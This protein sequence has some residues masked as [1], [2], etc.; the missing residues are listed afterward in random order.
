MSERTLIQLT[1]AVPDGPFRFAAPINLTIS[2]GETLILTGPNGSGKT[3]LANM[4]RGATRLSQGS[5]HTAA[6]IRIEYV[7]FHDQYT[8]SVD[9]GASAYQMRWNQG[10]MDEDFEPRVRDVLSLLPASADLI[11]T[12]DLMDR[13]IVSLSSGEWRRLQLARVL[14]KEP[15][16]LIIDNP[17]IGLDHAGRRVVAD[18]LQQLTARRPMALVLITSREDGLHEQKEVYTEPSPYQETRGGLPI[19]EARNITVRYGR[20]TILKDFSLNIREGEHWALKG[21]NGSGKST[22]LSLIC[23]DNPQGYACDITLFGRRR[24]TGES[25][26]EIK[27]NIGFVSPEMYRAYRRNLPVKVIVASGLHDTTGLFRQPTAD[28]IQQVSQWMERFGISSWAD[29]S[30]MTLSGGEQRWVLLCRAFVKN[31]QLLILDEPYHALDNHYRQM[32]TSIICDYCSQP[33]HTLIMV[34]H[35]D[36]DFPPIIDHCI[37]LKTPNKQ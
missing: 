6:N 33:R 19:L 25:I 35:Y 15:Q 18:M 2:E 13:T 30:Y 8:S 1:D 32:A 36:E 20:R 31:P 22:L 16:V 26:W 21:P 3:T 14:A 37:E 28:D 11:D 23:A 12:A 24:G 34:S 7:A 4:L 17:Y 5:R 27:K 10:A 29:R 9:T